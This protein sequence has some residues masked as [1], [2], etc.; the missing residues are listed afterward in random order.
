MI[1]NTAEIFN[2]C[3]L[4]KLCLSNKTRIERIINDHKLKQRRLHERY[5]NHD[6]AISVLNKMLELEQ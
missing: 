2:F 1:T 6:I 5:I 4:D 3:V